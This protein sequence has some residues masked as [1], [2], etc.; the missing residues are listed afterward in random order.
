ML[1]KNRT[2]FQIFDS[3]Q[4]QCRCKVPIPARKV[5]EKVLFE[6]GNCETIVPFKNDNQT[7]CD[8][9]VEM[10]NFNTRQPMMAADACLEVGR[11]T[12][13]GTVDSFAEGG[14]KGEGESM[15][16]MIFKFSS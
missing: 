10:G 11:P 9:V 14:A 15:E 3:L 7:A 5:D 2:P 13:A 1:S 16:E 8:S 4:K 12:S 6:G